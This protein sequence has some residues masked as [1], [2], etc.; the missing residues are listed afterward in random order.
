[1]DIIEVN[2]DRCS[3]CRECISVCPSPLA[4][5]VRTVFDG[6]KVIDI[7]QTKCIACGECVRHCKHGSRDYND[8]TD[9]F[10]KDLGERKMVIIA[11]PAIKAAFG[12]KWQAVLK[13][14]KQNGSDG[15]YDGAL[16]ADICTWNYCKS[17][18]SGAVRKVVSQHCPAIVRYMEIYH[19]D[20]LED[21]APLATPNSCE[22][23]YIRDYIKKNYVVAVLSPCPAMK[24]E[25]KE[26]EHVEYNVTFKRMKEYFRK[27]K[28]D[29]T[30]VA[31]SGMLYDFDDQAQGAMGGIYSAPGGMKY[32]LTINDPQLLAVSSDGR[33]SVYKDIDEFVSTA[34][35]KRPDVLEALACAGGCGFG[36]GAYDPDGVSS[37]GIK[38]MHRRVQVEARSRR[39]VA[40]N[41]LDKQFKVFEDRINP[42]SLKRVYP[43]PEK[44][45]TK[46]Q[47]EAV[48]SEVEEFLRAKEASEFPAATAQ[49]AAEHPAPE[50][51]ISDEE[52]ARI[53]DASVK[54]KS[55]SDSLVA[56][57]S[58][59]KEKIGALE[60][61]GKQSL[62]I[63]SIMENILTRV[64]E[65]CQQNE[66]I[67]ADSLPQLVSILDKLRAAVAS[68][69]TNFS[70]S[71]TGA[72]ELKTAIE[73]LS[74]TADELNTAADA[75]VIKE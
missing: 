30:N 65:F 49:P 35:D 24:L 45:P 56:D 17:L 4:N 59:V 75:A 7:D 48:T 63:T 29:F 62:S 42:K 31:E 67:D 58:A 69:N 26:T 33:D 20:R 9:R 44:K 74:V 13:W 6:R 18:D 46:E 60:E 34:P 38:N 37:L 36:L 64:T 55:I 52:L 41:G 19:P 72:Q 11:H 70:E 54:V 28:I 22:A 57:I 40:L 23:V 32:N 71:G 1:M 61:S 21:L 73:A 14:F 27:H 43:D 51:A 15:I 5:I 39:K 16:G 66:S 10:F 47:I 12:D 3:G 50:P 2:Y 68:L 25:F 53:T 8:D